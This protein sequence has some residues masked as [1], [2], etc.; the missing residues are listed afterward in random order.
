MGLEKKLVNLAHKS[1]G[2][3]K[4]L[5]ARKQIARRLV[6]YFHKKMNI[7][8]RDA[9]QIKISQ[10]ERYIQARKAERISARTLQNEM[11]AIRRIL[12]E[13]G[14]ERMLAEKRMSN[15]A[16]GIANAPRDGK[17]TA[18]TEDKYHQLLLSAEER[19]AG[20]AA[21]SRLGRELGLRMAEAVR[22]T[23][24]VPTWLDRLEAG[25]NKLTVIYGT[26]GKRVRDVTIHAIHRERV[27]AA[28]KNAYEVMNAQNGK[29]IDRPN[30]KQAMYRASNEARAN[31]LESKESFH[32][33]RYSFARAQYAEY[34]RQGFSER[35]ALSLT[36]VD[37][38]HG[39]GRGY[40]IK[41]VY[42]K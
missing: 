14:R 5:D 20:F 1:S 36:S 30:L 9:S 32:A 19:D 31:G 21:C 23:Q 11:S 40:Y 42:L 28:V 27:L 26:K 2:S 38:G 15:Q 33:L 25:K 7:Q 24:S 3:F 13:A 16:L 12:E 29:L 22:S 41:R 10:I 37:L 4:T 18:I 35:E 6:T 39:D 34:L 17:K 8:I